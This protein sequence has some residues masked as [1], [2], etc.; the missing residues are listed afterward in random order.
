MDLRVRQQGHKCRKIGGAVRLCADPHLEIRVELLAKAANRLNQAQKLGRVQL[1]SSVSSWQKQPIQPLHRAHHQIHGR[2]VAPEIAGEP[3]GEIEADLV[4]KGGHT[5]EIVDN[6]WGL[7]IQVRQLDLVRAKHRQSTDRLKGIHN[8][9][10]FE[11]R[12]RIP[13]PRGHP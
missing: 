13:P 9:V 3:N 11:Q 6:V 12:R 8:S 1:R 10:F 2:L 7:P 4:T 5:R